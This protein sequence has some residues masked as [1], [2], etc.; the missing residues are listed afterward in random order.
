MPLIDLG[1]GAFIDP[2]RIAFAAPV[3][4]PPNGRQYHIWL[5]GCP[6]VILGTGWQKI[7]EPILAE[8]ARRH[9]FEAVLEDVFLE[10]PR[11]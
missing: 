8:H 2:A 10:P 6:T 11:N 5:A 1:N 4:N 7:I 3:D 9:Q